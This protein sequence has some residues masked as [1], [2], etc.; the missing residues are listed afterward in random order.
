MEAKMEK[1]KTGRRFIFC[2]S[3]VSEYALIFMLGEVT[4]EDREDHAEGRGELD[5]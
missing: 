1:I 3:Q 4:A 5:F 2:K